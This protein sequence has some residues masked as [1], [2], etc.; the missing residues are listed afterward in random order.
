MADTQ[1][2]QVGEKFALA[3][4]RFQWVLQR[5]SKRK[6]ED[7]RKAIAFTDGSKYRLFAMMIRYGVPRDDALDVCERLPETFTE[8]LAGIGLLGRR[9]ASGSAISAPGAARQHP[10]S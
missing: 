8:L 9:G 7:D 4:D 6:G 10:R 2:C 1:F 5:R 3:Y